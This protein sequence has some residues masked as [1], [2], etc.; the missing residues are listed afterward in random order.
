MIGKEGFVVPSNKKHRKI[1]IDVGNIVIRNAV[2][3]DAPQVAR[4]IMEAMTDE[5]CR[6]FYG[7]SHNSME[8]LSMMTDLVRRGD[9][10]YSYNNTIC[11]V[12]GNLVVGILVC[13]DGGQLHR[14]RSP[15]IEETLRRFGSDFNDMPDETEDGELYIDSL[16]VADGYR[17]HGIARH[18]FLDAEDRAEALG[19]PILGLLVEKD[20]DRAKSLY[21]KVGFRYVNDRK[22]GGHTLSHLQLHV[23]L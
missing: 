7:D 11:A 17:R 3:T 16:A 22:W 18:L 19:I 21:N 1:M 14:L 20:N 4:L 10:Q 2:A 13:Y 6:H 23:P 8:F 5:C 9:T 15:F 12:S